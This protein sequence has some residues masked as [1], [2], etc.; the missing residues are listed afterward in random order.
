[1]PSTV[2]KE[3]HA[4]RLRAGLEFIAENESTT[5]ADVVAWVE[6]AVPPTEEERTVIPSNGRERWT[7]QFLWETTGLVK[8]GYVKKDG[9]GSWAIT[10]EGKR[11]LAD[12]TNPVDLLA[13]VNRRYKLWEASRKSEKRRAWLLRGTSVLG[14]NVVSEWLSNSF[15]SIAG[16][17]LAPPDRSVTVDQLKAVVQES[18]SHLKYA[19]R[20]QHEDEVVGFIARMSAG[21]VI[22]TKSGEAVYV[23]D[24]VGDWEWAEH[25]DGKSNVRRAVE[26]RNVD[27]PILLDELPPPL[28]ARLQTAKTL[29]DLTDDL[30]IIDLLTDT[31]FADSGD[32]EVAELV[33]TSFVRHNLLTD[34]PTAL[35]ASLL[36]DHAW[37][38]DVIELLNERRQIIFYGPPGTGKTFIASAIADAYAE[39]GEGRSRLVQFHPS[40]TYED[41]F[42]G[43]RPVAGETQ[44]TLS[45]ELRAGPL[46]KIVTQAMQQP[47]HPFFLIIDEINR[48]N[49]AKVFGELYFLLEYREKGVELLYSDE[50]DF[51]LPRNVYIIG[52]MNTA[53]RSIALI[54]SAMRRRFAFVSLD[55]SSEPT[56]SLL[57]RWLEKHNLPSTAALLLDQLND[58]IGDPDFQ[59][60]PSY[61]MKSK[62]HS[63]ARLE[64]VWR[65]SIIPLL[66]ERYFGEWDAQQKRFSFNTIWKLITPEPPAPD[67]DVAT[68]EST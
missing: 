4:A 42:E 27:T 16:A 50:A 40:Y 26:W 13:E 54:D 29:V 41:F 5:R 22:L 6:K 66:E 62:D 17:Q 43:F 68:P 1:V 34:P 19:Q 33:P 3:R 49:L 55:P 46:R 44:G 60:G 15:V 30:G 14:S 36:V 67:A 61:F 51:S 32:I 48:A 53:D 10:D 39:R 28:P 8:A 11:A 65:T 18:Y 59:I 23:G 63:R 52:T 45:F 35:A 21:D 9:R 2:W 47:E 7:Y 56:K 25:P 57:K 37:L 64:R 20:K 38:A 31:Q 12:F 24:V 58:R